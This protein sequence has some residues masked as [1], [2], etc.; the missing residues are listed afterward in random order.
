MLNRPR[1][2]PFW[3]AYVAIAGALLYG[4]FHLPGDGLFSAGRRVADPAGSTISTLGDM[5]KLITSLNTA[6]LAGAATLTLKGKD[7]TSR[8]ERL[9][10]LLIMLVFA[11]G[12]VSYFGVYS[13]YVRLLSMV[14]GGSINP[15]ET[16]M[17]W[18]IRLQFWGVIG[19]VAA[20]GLVFARILEGRVSSAPKT[21]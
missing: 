17:L 6:M 1:R 3:P 5:I 16:R 19:G 15:M 12:A 20:L 7:W 21:P 11:G 10:S 4:A 2:P 13:A 9:D 14:N 8:W 18:T